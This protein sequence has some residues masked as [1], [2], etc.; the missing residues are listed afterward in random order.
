MCGGVFMNAGAVQVFITDMQGQQVPVRLID[1]HDKTWRVEFEAPVPG[2][3]SANVTFSGLV[4]PRSPFTINVQPATDASKVQVRG[5][6]NSE[7][8]PITTHISNQI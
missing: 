6:P 1:N 4:V 7:P 2:V 5:L 3:Y 8:P